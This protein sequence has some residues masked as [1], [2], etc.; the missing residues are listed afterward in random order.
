MTLEQAQQVAKV[1]LSATTADQ[2]KAA[3][4]D[5]LAAIA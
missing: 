5:A 1:A 2:C 3:V 4:L